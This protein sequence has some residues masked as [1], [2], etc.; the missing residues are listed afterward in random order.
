MRAGFFQRAVASASNFSRVGRARAAVVIPKQQNGRPRRLEHPT[1][2]I[3]ERLF[4]AQSSSR[5]GRRG[6]GGDGCGERTRRGGG[7]AC[8]AEF[9][10]DARACGRSEESEAKQGNAPVLAWSRPRR[11][12]SEI[13]AAEG[14]WTVMLLLIASAAPGTSSRPNSACSRHGIKCC[15]SCC[16]ALHTAARRLSAR[17][18]RS[19]RALWCMHNEW[20]GWVRAH[21]SSREKAS[22][23][24]PRR[25]KAWC[26]E[27]MRERRWA[28]ARAG[29]SRSVT[30]AT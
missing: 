4:A 25:E 11:K 14:P 8:A 20:N 23:E 7:R 27:S 17:R 16:C 13:L 5:R 24:N 26:D 6:A 12:T 21:R 10:A 9:A 19:G 22:V 29:A 30:K 1:T 15:C 18:E 2:K 3:V 28:H